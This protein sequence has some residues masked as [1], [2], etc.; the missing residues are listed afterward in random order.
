MVWLLAALGCATTEDSADTA[1]TLEPTLS[2]VQAEVFTP[3]CAFSTCHGEGEGSAN[4]LLTDGAAFAGLVGVAAEGDANSGA[5][6][7]GSVR[8]V[9]GDAASSYLVAKL[10]GGGDIVGDVMPDPAGLDAERLALVVAWI[11]AG[12]ADD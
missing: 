8:V 1:G 9:A 10:G 4:L 7:D 11:D 12:A 3:S 6:P 2:N 5:P